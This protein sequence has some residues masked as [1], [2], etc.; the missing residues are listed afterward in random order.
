MR[1]ILIVAAVS[2]A[3]TA[4][5]ACATLPGSGNADVVNAIK[6]I[7][8]D[9]NCGHTDRISGNLGGL[10]GNNLNLFLERT[11]PPRAPAAPASPP[12]ASAE[13]PPA[14]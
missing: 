4:L 3:A 13:A 5:S 14:S 2:L 7:A 9:P 10:S 8:T 11:C 1:G 12:A 6:E